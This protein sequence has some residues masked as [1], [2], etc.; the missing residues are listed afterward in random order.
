MGIFAQG[1]YVTF[2]RECRPDLA[3]ILEHLTGAQIPD[4]M[5]SVMSA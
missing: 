3:L 2:L 4:A 5:R 1:P